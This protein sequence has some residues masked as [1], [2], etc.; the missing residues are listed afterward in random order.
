MAKNGFV[1]CKVKYETA[2]KLWDAVVVGNTAEEVSQYIRKAV[3]V[4]KITNIETLSEV[5]G[6]TDELK[7]RL[8]GVKETIPVEAKEIEPA[9]K[10]PYCPDGEEKAFINKTSLKIHIGKMHKEV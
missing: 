6:I 8:S 5:H 4:V 3:P 10:C 7:K 1:V 2:D 9:F